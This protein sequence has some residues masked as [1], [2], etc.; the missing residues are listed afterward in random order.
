VKEPIGDRVGIYDEGGQKKFYSQESADGA[1]EKTKDQRERS[2]VIVRRLGGAAAPVDILVQFED[3]QVAHEQ[4]DGQYRWIKFVYDKAVKSAE[5]DPGRRLA[6]E[7]NLTNNSR[8]A[9]GDNRAA[10]KWYLRWIFWLENLFMAA[11]FFS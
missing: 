11:S 6:L 7:A 2:T 8:T 5:V 4:W 10:A 1:A 3:G 9:T